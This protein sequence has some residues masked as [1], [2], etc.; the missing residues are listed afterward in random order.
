MPGTTRLVYFNTNQVAIYGTFQTGNNATITVSNSGTDSS[1]SSGAGNTV[2]VVNQ[3]QFFIGS[4]S[5]VGTNFEVTCT[6]SA[7]NTGNS[8]IVGQVG[9]GVGQM[10]FL[11]T[12]TMNDGGNLTAINN[13]SA[14]VNGGQIVLSNGFIQSSGRSNFYAINHGSLIGVFGHGIF[15][16]GSTGGDV[17]INLTNS[18]LFIETAGSTFEIGGLNGDSSSVVQSMQQLIINT[19]SDVSAVFDGVIENFPSISSELV[20]QGLGTQ[21]LTGFNTYTGPTFVNQG[22]LNLTGTISGDM[23]INPGG[24]LIG[25]GSVLGHVVNDGTISP[26]ESIGTITFGS[27]TGNSDRD[28]C[29]RVKRSRSKRPDRCE[30]PC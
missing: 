9:G 1:I 21:K 12:L 15:I 13:A 4:T 22:I 28:L 19:D 20:K 6:N 10:V 14:T 18:D 11:D 26:G 2:G 3:S 25:T 17:I 24:T 27:F 5:E 30:R 7:N 23:S 16:S 8:P 29:G